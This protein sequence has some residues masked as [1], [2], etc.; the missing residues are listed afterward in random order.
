MPYLV[1]LFQKWIGHHYVSNSGFDYVV[2]GVFIAPVA[3]TRR[4]CHSDNRFCHPER[5]RRV[6]SSSDPP[7]SS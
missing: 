1:K 2:I 4:S 7:L 5:S 3:L 6:D